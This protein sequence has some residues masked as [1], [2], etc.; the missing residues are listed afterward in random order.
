[1]LGFSPGESSIDRQ[2]SPSVFTREEVSPLA[3]TLLN[4]FSVVTG[5]RREWILPHYILWTSWPGFMWIASWKQANVVVS[6]HANIDYPLLMAGLSV[7]T[8]L[9]SD[10]A[11]NGLVITAVLSQPLLMITWRKHTFSKPMFW[12]LD[13]EVGLPQGIRSIEHKSSTKLSRT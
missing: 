13:S 12:R 3:R 6:R 8:H 2:C 7:R 11:R 9:S 5:Q 1:M 4:H 10:D